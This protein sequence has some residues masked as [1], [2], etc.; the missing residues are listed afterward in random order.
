M[1]VRN[2]EQLRL[3]PSDHRTIGDLGMS[4]VVFIPV[5]S[6]PAVPQSRVL[7]ALTYRQR[8]GPSAAALPDS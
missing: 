8:T 3:A 2:A 5:T 6:S 7:S 1:F 4:S